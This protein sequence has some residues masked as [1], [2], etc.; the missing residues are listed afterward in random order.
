MTNSLF[1]EPGIDEKIDNAFAPIANAWE[2][3]VLTSI[4]I[5]E[6]KNMP[7]VVLFLVQHFSPY[8]LALLI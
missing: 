4:P 8:T 6:G 5:A 7:I 3:L 2:S 1:F